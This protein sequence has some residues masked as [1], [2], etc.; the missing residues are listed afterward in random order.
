MRR[1]GKFLIVAGVLFVLVQFFRPA[2]PT[3]PATAEVQASPAVKQI[4][5]KSC[6]SC[7]SDQRRLSWFDILCPATGWCGTTS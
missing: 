5:Q 6:Y 7:H 3:K 2:I 4:L 1:V